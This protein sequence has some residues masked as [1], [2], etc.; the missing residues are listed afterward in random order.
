M[1]LAGGI[2]SCEAAIS[3]SSSPSCWSS[4][5]G[6]M[7]TFLVRQ[8]AFSTLVVVFVV[9][10]VDVG[11]AG[12][13][14]IPVFV[15]VLVVILVPGVLLLVGSFGGGSGSCD[16]RSGWNG[17]GS[18][19]A[20]VACEERGSLAWNELIV[21]VKYI[22]LYILFSLLVS[23]LFSRMRF[24]RFVQL[25]RIRPMGNEPPSINAKCI[26]RSVAPVCQF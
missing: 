13:V 11:F 24:L 10:N 18:T 20:P 16:Q 12:G 2:G 6:G 17:G 3:S 1:M 9:G 25:T 26:P 5:V 23:S 22:Y 7:A 8:A 19:R 14:L 15:D 21:V 4:R